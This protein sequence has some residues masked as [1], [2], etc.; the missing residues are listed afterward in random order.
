MS[1]Q[2][3]QVVPATVGARIV[4]VRGQKVMLDH[5]LAEVS[6]VAT[7]ALNQAV[8]RNRERFP[9]DFLF[10]L[11][12]EEFRDLRSQSVTS[13]GGWG[14]RRQPPWAFTEH[15]AIMAASVLNSPRAVEM[16]VFVVRAFVR[17]H[18]LSRTDALLAAKLTA[19]ERKVAGHDEALKRM[20]ATLRALLSPPVKPRRQIGFGSG[21]PR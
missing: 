19:L 12:P 10:Q 20:F 14:G 4:E 9:E 8:K 1:G 3:R 6:G 21:G 2:S 7:K 16:S 5:D 15:G 17:L 18:D 11:A 13:S